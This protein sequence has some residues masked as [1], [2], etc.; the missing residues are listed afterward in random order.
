[1]MI[2]DMITKRVKMNPYKLTSVDSL[3]RSFFKEAIYQGW[4]FRERSIIFNICKDRSCDF[5]DL[6]SVLR[7][8]I[9]QIDSEY[10]EPAPI[11][12]NLWDTGIDLNSDDAEFFIYQF[13][14]TEDFKQNSLLITD[15]DDFIRRFKPC[16]N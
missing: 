15:T 16:L 8:Y 6:L 13:S 11:K 12:S 9:D 10:S 7:Q 2:K 1:M 3:M 4:S 5:E 14:L